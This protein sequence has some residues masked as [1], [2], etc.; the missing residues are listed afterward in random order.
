LKKVTVGFSPKVQAAP[1][2][3]CCFFLRS[4]GTKQELEEETIPEV[5]NY[6]IRPAAVSC[7]TPL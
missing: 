6:G 3:M 5:I 4:S 2:Q 1:L 7:H